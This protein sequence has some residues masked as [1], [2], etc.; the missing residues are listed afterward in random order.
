VGRTAAPA[1][2][3]RLPAGPG[4]YRFRDARRRV[5]YVGR[6]VELRRR[7]SSYWGDLGERAHLAP[8]VARVAVVE[9]VACDSEHEAAWLERNLLERRLPPWNRTGGAE[10]PA[11]ICLDPGPAAPGLRVVHE[12]DLVP[13]LRWFGPYLG[14]QKVR[15][16]VTAL[17]RVL[18]LPYAGDR[19]RGGQRDLARVFGVGPGDRASLV[20]ALTAVLDR[21]PAAVA[22]VRA[23]LVRRRDDAAGGL[24]FE[25]AATLREELASV[26]WVVSP[27]RAALPE[28]ADFDVHGWAGGVLVGFEVRA[29]R[30]GGWSQHVCAE[31]AAAS[32]L[33]ATPPSWAAFARRGAELAAA[34][35]RP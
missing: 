9:A 6:A 13:G 34:L 18:P 15:R 2:V 30:L 12:H 32:R 26:E 19:L 25:L 16:A 23:E 35:L 29:G 10:V 7:V 22:A 11:C 4:V 1:A 3:A 8:M 5:L 28:P 17:H 33:A 31:V 20:A 21:E 14:G 24:A 27:Q